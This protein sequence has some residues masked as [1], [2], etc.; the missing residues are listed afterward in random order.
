MVRA[1]PG[2]VNRLLIEASTSSR[3]VRLSDSGVAIAAGAGCHADASGRVVCQLDARVRLVQANLADGDDRADIVTANLRAAQADVRGGR[4]DDV[5]PW[6]G[7]VATRLLG[8][9]GRRPAHGERGSRRTTS[10]GRRRPGERPWSR[11]PADPRRRRRRAVAPARDKTGSLEVRT[12]ASSTHATARQSRLPSST[13]GRAG[14]SPPRTDPTCPRRGSA[15]VPPVRSVVVL[16]HPDVEQEHHDA[17]G[18]DHSEPGQDLC[19]S[20]GRRG[21]AIGAPPSGR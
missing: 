20:R 9:R 2:G 7:A 5:N 19:P 4:G 3:A 15:G 1:G 6:A 18:E 11:R 13:A 14:T 16:D 10:P 12:P 17:Q 8:Q 21:S